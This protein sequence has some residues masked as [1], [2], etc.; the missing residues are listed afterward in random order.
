MFVN[1][2]DVKSLT[3]CFLCAQYRHP[4]QRELTGYSQRQQT[5]RVHI[6]CYIH[7]GTETVNST[8][9][10]REDALLSSKIKTKRNYL[11]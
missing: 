2:S 7:S 3:F 10:D 4:L 6:S 11:H 5:A 8:V 1:S 9:L